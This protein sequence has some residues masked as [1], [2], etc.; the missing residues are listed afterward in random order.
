ME[1][2][3]IWLSSAIFDRDFVYRDL[4]AGRLVVLNQVPLRTLWRE[5]RE[6]QQQ[7]QVVK[8]KGDLPQE[9]R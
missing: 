2:M 1:W 4:S 8:P 6:N 3:V 7:L 9:Y 5:R